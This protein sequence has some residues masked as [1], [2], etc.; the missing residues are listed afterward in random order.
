MFFAA[1]ADPPT[2]VEGVH[3]AI[4]A[5]GVVTVT[6]EEIDAPSFITHGLAIAAFNTAEAAAPS[7]RYLGMGD[8]LTVSHLVQMPSPRKALKPASEH[9]LRDSLL[10]CL[11]SNGGWIPGGR[12]SGTHGLVIRSSRYVNGVVHI[13]VVVV[14]VMRPGFKGGVIPRRQRNIAPTGGPSVGVAVGG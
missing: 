3:I 5:D 8:S 1:R 10:L 7:T 9:G 14:V 11:G 4:T 13:I 12:G 6:W 2:R